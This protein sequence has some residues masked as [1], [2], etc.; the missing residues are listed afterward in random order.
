MDGVSATAWRQSLSKGDIVE[1]KG[2][3]SLR[4]RCFSYIQDVSATYKGPETF[5]TVSRGPHV[6]IF[7]KQAAKWSLS[8]PHKLAYSLTLLQLNDDCKARLLLQTMELTNVCSSTALPGAGPEEQ[9]D[10][11]EPTTVEKSFRNVLHRIET[12]TR[13]GDRFCLLLQQTNLCSKLSRSWK[14]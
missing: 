9:W 14:Y 6:S 7:K 3:C 12:N 4:N 8:L 10:S 2:L 5:P 1:K 13:S 11:T